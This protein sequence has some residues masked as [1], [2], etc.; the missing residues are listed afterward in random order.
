MS[1]KYNSITFVFVGTTGDQAKANALSSMLINMAF[2]LAIVP[3]D[4][5]AQQTAC[6]I[7]EESKPYTTAV[8]ES[9]AIDSQSVEAAVG[10]INNEVVVDQRL[11]VLVVGHPPLLNVTISR[12][13]PQFTAQVQD[14]DFSVTGAVRI[15]VDRHGSATLDIVGY[16]FD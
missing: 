11:D 4:S 15:R 10:G 2:D 6:I 7:T 13:F 14:F 3:P 8:L 12:M 9:L 5:D 16:S 1:F